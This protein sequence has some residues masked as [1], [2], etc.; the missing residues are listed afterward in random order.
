MTRT[1]AGPRRLPL[2]TLIA[3]ILRPLFTLLY[4]VEI[5]GAERIPGAGPC[6]LAANH[7][8]VLDGFFLA[9]ASRRQLRFMAKAELYRYALLGRVMRALGCFPVERGADNGRAVSA[10]VRLLERGEAIGIF[11]QGTCLPWLDRSY[12]RGAARLALATGAPL[13][14]VR[15]VGTAD[16]LEPGTHRVGFPRVRILVGEPIR[17]ERQ[18]PTEETASEL[19]AQLERAI[20]TLS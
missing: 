5:V 9:I 10:G 13:V 2:Y 17:V 7:E 14:P 3:G 8:S 18:E 4:R 1:P 20:G 15:L 12:R 19:T 6:I 16:A 11:P